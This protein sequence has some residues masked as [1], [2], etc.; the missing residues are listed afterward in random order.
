MCV[1]QGPTIGTVCLRSTDRKWSH[2]PKCDAR[3]LPQFGSGAVRRSESGTSQ[4][5]RLRL[6]A[7]VGRPQRPSLCRRPAATRRQDRCVLLARTCSLCGANR[8]AWK[9][10]STTWPVEPEPQAGGRGSASCAGEREEPGGNH[11]WRC[12][13]KQRQ[14][15]HERRGCGGHGLQLLSEDQRTEC[16]LLQ[17][18]GIS[19]DA[20]QPFKDDAY[21]FK[22][23]AASPRRLLPS[24]NVYE[25]IRF[26]TFD[27]RVD[28]NSNG[29]LRS[30]RFSN[31]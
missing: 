14:H 12:L 10:A 11:S 15:T 30:K 26:F 28:E 8:H 25:S 18:R 9:A 21:T 23:D 2:P 29:L 3:A 27:A 1:T 17:L 20:S 22:V 7:R 31:T 13:W 5:P 6:E 4:R 24:L 16:Q 19:Q